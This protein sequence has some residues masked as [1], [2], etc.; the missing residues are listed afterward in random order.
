MSVLFRIKADEEGTEALDV[1]EAVRNAGRNVKDVA[2]LQGLLDPALDR[3]ARD[4]VGI[5]SL[6]RIHKLAAGDGRRAAGTDQPDVERVGMHERRGG[7]EARMTEAMIPVLT[8]NQ[9]ATVAT[10]LRSRAAKESRS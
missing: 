3:R 1:L 5:G 6:F 2:G 9:R 7:R 10:H 8:P 4:V